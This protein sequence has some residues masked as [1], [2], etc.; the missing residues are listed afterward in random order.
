[1][2]TSEPRRSGGEM[3]RQLDNGAKKR[4][5]TNKLRNGM[6]GWGGGGRA[7]EGP[8]RNTNLQLVSLVEIQRWTQKV[9]AG[10]AKLG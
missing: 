1:M 8:F 5:T 2:E 10:F 7:V 6:C 4:C 9:R 3:V